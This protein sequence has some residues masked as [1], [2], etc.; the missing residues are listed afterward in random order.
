MS[1]L[2]YRIRNNPN[3]YKKSTPRTIIKPGSG[4][5]VVDKTVPKTNVRKTT[6]TPATNP[7]ALF[8]TRPAAAPKPKPKPKPIIKTPYTG[9]DPRTHI[10]VRGGKNHHIANKLG[11]KT[12]IKP[13]TG[14]KVTIKK[15]PPK[16]VPAPP[17]K[18]IK[19]GTGEKVWDT[20]DV[21][22]TWPFNPGDEAPRGSIPQ[23]GLP[24]PEDNDGDDDVMV[25]GDTISEDPDTGEISVNDE[26]TGRDRNGNPVDTDDDDD[27]GNQNSNNNNNNNNNNGN[28]NNNNNG[29]ADLGDPPAGFSD[30]DDWIDAWLQYMLSKRGTSIGGLNENYEE[31]GLYSSSD[32]RYSIEQLEA[33]L[34]AQIAAEGSEKLRNYGNDP[35]TD[36]V[37][38][39]DALIKA[40]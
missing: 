19:P 32:R 23:P 31:R 8:T 2:S 10:P 21:R 28:N 7:V 22:T 35:E 5:K 30:W 13:G 12:I 9:P 17:K 33:A 18:I 39:W 38:Q 29:N 15:P 40:L 36:L 11:Y 37:S 27:A 1:F 4:R 26:G 34:Q 14:E 24:D 3:Y 6:R 16:T 20:P 25:G